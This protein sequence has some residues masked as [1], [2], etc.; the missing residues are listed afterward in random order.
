M[1]KPLTQISINALKPGPARREVPDGKVA[2]LYLVVQPT[3]AMSWAVRYRVDGKSRK[4][5]LGPYPSLD[6][7]A[8]RRLAQKALADVAD[9]KDPAA[10]R[11]AAKAEARA[12]IGAEIHT[13]EKVAKQFVERYAR[14]RN[15]SWEE[16]S[17]LLDK[18]VV[19]KWGR[20]PLSSITRAEVHDL[21]DEIVD[22]PAP[23]VANRV[24]A[25]FRRLC[26]W[27]VERGIIEASPCAQV[28]APAPE[29]SRDRVLTDDEIR[30]AWEAFD[31]EGFPFGAIGKLLML[32]AAR[33]DEV[34]GMTWGELDL[35]G[36]LWRISK[37]RC[38][39][40]LEHVIPLSDAAIRVLE[41]LPRIDGGKEAT[42]FVFTTTGQTAV[43]GHSRFKE[44]IDVAIL[45]A[46]RKQAE[47][48][49]ED[50][51]G[52]KAPERW[53]LHDARRTAA[54]GMAALGIA[55]HVV[56][57][58]LGHKSGVIRGVAAVYNRHNYFEEKKTALD[59]WARRLD[60]IVTGRKPGNVVDLAKARAV[61]GR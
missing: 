16:T 41:G 9:E 58:V 27:A 53:T 24:L 49:G 28:K 32:T 25:A 23:I 8:A 52:V 31:K 3:G 45:A 29:R 57:A 5:T 15:R 51:D 13:V 59:A 7:A 47:E 56:E 34:T 33:R 10:L 14:P 43:S 50:P 22:R 18:E 38:K 42:G 61:D 19:S 12:K 6:L 4:H 39:N 44:R 60:E 54:S 20:R 21:L 46:L 40:G 35:A 55:P 1:A 26:N 2:G 11:K 30:M 48:R 17:R 37:E 36:K